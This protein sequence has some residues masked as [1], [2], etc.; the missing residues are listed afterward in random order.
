M[1]RVREVM[2]KLN[3]GINASF[4]ALLDKKWPIERA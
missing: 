3:F 1:E 4:L 2:K